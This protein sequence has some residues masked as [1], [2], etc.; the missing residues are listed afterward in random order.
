MQVLGGADCAG[1]DWEP[2]LPRPLSGHCMARLGEQLVVV[3]GGPD[4][5]GTALLH[6]P[7][8]GWREVAAPHKDRTG[9]TCTPVQL[10]GQQALLVAG[11]GFSPMDLAEVA[12]E[13]ILVFNSRRCDMQVYLPGNDSWVWTSW[14]VRERTG[15]AVV[16]LGTPARPLPTV[17]G[18][19]GGDYCCKVTQQTE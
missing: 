12:G 14:M 3:G 16:E 4:S 1:L 18:G 7:G 17:L 6:S 10:A 11:N 5:Y 2:A 9:H 13:F 19:Y 15:G 8:Q